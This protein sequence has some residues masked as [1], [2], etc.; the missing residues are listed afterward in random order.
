MT[1]EETLRYRDSPEGLCAARDYLSRALRREAEIALDLARLDRLRR[2]R[3]RTS[4]AE[5]EIRRREGDVTAGYRALRALRG[6]IEA[7]ISRVPG[8]TVRAVLRRHYLEG[9]PFFR[10]AMDLHYEERQIYRF[11]RQGL[12]HVA[13]QLACGMMPGGDAGGSAPPDPQPQSS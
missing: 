2:K 8:D 4:A 9:A 10:I 3:G 7:A 12:R 11:Q 13:A 6:E 1:A 5:E